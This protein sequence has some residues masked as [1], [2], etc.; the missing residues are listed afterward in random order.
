MISNLDRLSRRVWCVLVCLALSCAMTPPACADRPPAT[1]LLP[2]STVV[3]VSVTDA[4]DMAEGF[5][6]TALGR[7]SKDPQL[8]PLI[9]HLYGSL[10]EAV[11]GVQDRIGLSLDELLDVPQGEITFAL[12]APEEGPLAMVLLLD[13][14]DQMSNARKLLERAYAA[15]DN[16]P[17]TRS[18][19]TIAGTKVVIYDGLGPRRR[20]AM[21]FEKD[22]TI[23]IGSDLEVVKELLDVWNGGKGSTAADNQNLTSVMQCC[24]GGGEKPHLMWYVDPIGIMRSVGQGNTGAQ[25]A[26][27]MLPALGLDGLL[28]VGGTM[29]FD[30][31]QF[32]SVMHAHVLLENPRGGVIKMI[33]LESGDVKPEPWV[34]A[35]AASYTTLHWNVE[36][37]YSTL[38]TVYD[39]F[40]GDGALAKALEQRILGPTGIDFE[41]EILKSLDGRVT[42]ITRIERP[43]TVRS[44][45]TLLGLKLKDAATVEKALEKL[46]KQSNGGLSRETYA[47]KKY[48]QVRMPRMGDLPEDQRPPLPCFGILGDYLLAT[49]RVSL[50]EKA[51]VTAAGSES[52]ACEL[53][54]KL[55]ASKIKRQSGGEQPAM[56]SFNRPEE[57]MEM[58]YTLATAEAARQGLNRQADNNRFF[59]ALDTA[60]E[61][62]PLPPFAVIRRYLAPGGAMV[63]DDETGIHYMMFSLRRKSD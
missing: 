9:G 7:M 20:K 30:T 11:A 47:G 28:A 17:A 6:N 13:A 59:K 56:I 55:V 31:E 51:V 29:T 16:S 18:E 25:L 2:E 1:E 33:A 34:P 46:S 39:S 42:M 60:L 53:D 19:K 37:T 35:D 10:S 22:S 40:R 32:D 54:F 26:L 5:M 63:V 27:A 8:K 38:A 36:K 58:L 49:D 45:A 43:I 48:Y 57:L 23:V 50:F 14:G 15:A 12:V 52:L 4:P 41:K 24:R 61:E 21:F 44:R 3:L 62:N